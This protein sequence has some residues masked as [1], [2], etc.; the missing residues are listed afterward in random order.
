[1][2]MLM[3]MTNNVDVDDDICEYDNAVDGDVDNVNIIKMMLMMVCDDIMIL[4][5]LLL[6]LLFMMIM[7]M[8]MMLEKQ[9]YKLYINIKL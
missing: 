9:H 7:M 6:M 2:M 1:M 4:S 5:L 3:M 8:M